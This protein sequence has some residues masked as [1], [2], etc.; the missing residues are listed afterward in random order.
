[1]LACR[2]LDFCEPKKFGPTEDFQK[3]PRT[4]DP[5]GALLEILGVDY[6]F[7][8]PRRK[9]IPE[10]SHARRLSKASAIA[11]KDARAPAIFRA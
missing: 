9:S 2:R 10:L 7:A 6:L 1:M 5:I 4:L 11:S 3:Y 8:P